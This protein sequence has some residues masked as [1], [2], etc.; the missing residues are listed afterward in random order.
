MG[1][2]P[3]GAIDA[4][5]LLSCRVISV[6]TGDTHERRR[7]DMPQPSLPQIPRLVSNV[8]PHS[9]PRFDESAETGA[10]IPAFRSC[11]RKTVASE[12]GPHHAVP[13]RAPRLPSRSATAAGPGLARPRGGSA[14]RTTRS[15]GH[16]RSRLRLA[17][18]VHDLRRRGVRRPPGRDDHRCRDRRSAHRIA[19]PSGCEHPPPAGRRRAHR[20]AGPERRAHRRARDR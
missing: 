13:H 10:R 15:H 1:R 19:A 4:P 2:S 3:P 20:H 12:H 17:R 14:R 16:G 9:G 5:V 8:T 7:G 11:A 18:T 6:P